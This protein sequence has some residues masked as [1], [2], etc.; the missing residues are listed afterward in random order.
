MPNAK[1]TLDFSLLKTHLLKAFFKELKDEAQNVGLELELIPF[2]DEAGKKNRPV[3]LFDNQGGGTIPLLRRY[4]ADCPTLTFETEQLGMPRFIVKEGG[5]LT[6]EP[7]GQIEYS[8]PPKPSMS[9]AVADMARV[10]RQL[11]EALTPHGIWFFHGGLNP[12]YQVEEIPLQLQKQRYRSMDRFFAARGPFG[13][14]MMRLSTSLQINLDVGTASTAPRRWMAAN[15]LAPLMVAAFANSPFCGRE[16]MNAKSFRSVIWQNL[17]HSRT[18]VQKG[19]EATN[20]D[21][22]P[23]EQYFQFA[24]DA[25]CM[26][27]P[28]AQ[29]NMV[30]DGHFRTFRYWMT[31]GFRGFF[32]D[33][34]DWTDHLST[35]F[36]VVRP[37]GFFELRYIDAQSKAYWMVP[38]VILTHLLYDEKAREAIIDMM[39]RYRTTLTGM[40]R[41]AAMHGLADPELAD[42]VKRMFRIAFKAAE[43]AENSDLLKICELF[44]SDLTYLGKTPADALIALNQGTVFSPEQYWNFERTNLEHVAPWL[45]KV[46]SQ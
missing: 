16:R 21:P 46:C 8:G 10:L 41:E 40:M 37:R 18:G 31:H 30:F 13:Q 43:S 32:P 23:V 3:G 22:C 1:S 15:L 9:L 29:G 6:F 33:F 24:L 12:W 39:Q 28:D 44:F 7:G 25:Y 19:F 26:R 4:A 11:E 14:K 20:Y 42:C 35:L 38:G 5:Q 2:G 17:D 36:P 45:D 27:L 34:D